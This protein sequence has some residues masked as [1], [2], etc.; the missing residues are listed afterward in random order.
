MMSVLPA[1]LRAFESFGVNVWSRSGMLDVRS[2]RRAVHD[3]DYF[4]FVSPS[5]AAVSP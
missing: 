2:L 3:G 1:M 5:N 4:G